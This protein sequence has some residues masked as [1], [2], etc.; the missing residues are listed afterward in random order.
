MDRR[1]RHAKLLAPLCA[2]VLLAGSTASLTACTALPSDAPPQ[3]LGQFR[4]TPITFNPPKPQPGRSPDLLLR[5]FMRAAAVPTNRHAAAR[6]F[7]TAKG[8][9]DWDDQ[10]T[11]KVIER[12][13]VNTVAT[14]DANSLVMQVRARSMGEVDKQG[15]FRS[16]LSTHTFE[17]K[18]HRNGK[19]WLIDRFPDELLVDR[20][21][22]MATYESQSIYYLDVTGSRVVPDPRWLYAQDSHLPNMLMQLLVQDPSPQL[23]DMVASELP[24][25]AHVSAVPGAQGNGVDVEISNYQAGSEASRRRLA[26]QF[27]FTFE[28]ARIHGPFYITVDGNPLDPNHRDGWTAAD[29]VHYDPMYA[30]HQN[31]VQL[32]AITSDGLMKVSSNLEP[33]KGPLGHSQDLRSASFSRG[34]EMI[35]VVEEVRDKER[36]PLEVKMGPVGGPLVSVMRGSRFSRPTWG[37]TGLDMWIVSGDDHIN[38]IVWQDGRSPLVTRV[39]TSHLTRKPDFNTLSISPDGV[40]LAY[41]SGGKLYIATIYTSRDGEVSLRNPQRIY[42]SSDEVVLSVAWR[43]A[44]ELLVGGSLTDQP[45]LMVSIDG[46]S[47]TPLGIR[48]VTAP[49]SVVVAN[50]T[51]IYVQDSRDV[52]RLE[53]GSEGFWQDVPALVNSPRAIPVLEG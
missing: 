33:V 20:E 11:L 30:T 51:G 16:N 7:L 15:A 44:T 52:M 14:P 37:P 39:D 21:A 3:S 46:A 13:D 40:R 12:I 5:D 10:A 2:L 50:P 27:I 43:T 17:V 1:S 41:I 47:V 23:H 32:H 29:V 8:N 48:N 9:A 28:R 31:P 36:T 53:Q 19:Q 18:M 4:R 6:L 42:I 38:R 45:V 34:G 26:A 35:G 24:A 49:V 22:F 25:S